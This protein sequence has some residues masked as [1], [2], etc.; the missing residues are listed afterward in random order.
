MHVYIPTCI[1][2]CS[3]I[4]IYLYINVNLYTPLLLVFLDISDCYNHKVAF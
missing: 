3:V 1:H 4:Y 2:N